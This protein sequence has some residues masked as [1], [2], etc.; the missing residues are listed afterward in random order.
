MKTKSSTLAAKMANLRHAFIAHIPSQLAEVRDALASASLSQPPLNGA[1]QV[2]RIFHNLKGSGAT[3]GLKQISLAAEAAEMLIDKVMGES[4]SYSP[5]FAEEIS[6]HI[7]NLD[8]LAS[9]ALNDPANAVSLISDTEKTREPFRPSDSPQ[10]RKNIYICDDDPSQ[11]EHIHSQLSCFGYEVKSFSS[12]DQLRQAVKTESPDAVIM[13]VVFPEGVNAGLEVIHDLQPDEGPKLPVVFISGRSDFSARLQAVKAGGLAFLTKPLRCLDIVEILDSLTSNARPE[14][15][16]VLVVDDEPQIATLHASILEEAGMAVRVIH[17]PAQVVEVLRDFRPELVLMDMYMHECTGRELSM[18]IRQ[19][20]E[21]ISIPIIYLSSETDMKKQHS[22]MAVGADG[23]LVKPINP[24]ELV[25]AV[26]VRAERM[27]TLRALMVRDSL[28]GLFNHTATKQFLE[29]AVA[30]A[31]RISRTV[32]FAMIDLDNFK[33]VND[34]YGHPVGDQVL[35]ALSRVL[36]QQLRQNDLVGRFGGEEFAVVL[37]DTTLDKAQS[38]LDTL[39]EDFSSIKFWANDS[40]FSVTFSA[41]V[42]EFP[43]CDSADDLC[44]QADKALYVAKRKG[45]NVVIKADSGKSGA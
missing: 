25:S 11:I 40:E 34:T 45:R 30:N 43:A 27:R 10:D 36:R 24:R 32:C 4:Q 42:A 14:P 18:I 17:N 15:F 13:D 3:F 23:F 16:R 35:L 5:E 2:K 8:R 29:S 12:I 33:A 38:I 6:Q 19:M 39:R 26:T 21:Y 31:R 7:A 1:A 22:A 28:T 41:G 37:L 44:E 20:P 9:Q